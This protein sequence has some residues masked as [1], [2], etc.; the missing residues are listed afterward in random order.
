[1]SFRI[2]GTRVVW[3]AEGEKSE[4][5]DIL[6]IPANDHLW[7]LSGPGLELKKAHGKDFELEA[8][9]LGPLEPGQV[10]VTPGAPCGFRWL[11]HAV[12]MTPELDWSAG[13]GR[14]AALHSIRLAKRAAAS[15]VVFYPLHRGVHGR[16]E[17]PVREM[18]A[19]LLE[20]LGESTGIKSVAVLYHGAEEKALLHETF[21]QLLSSPPS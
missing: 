20:G 15:G 21:L 9:R 10:A 7:M 17:G 8:V 1:M 6:V 14:T 2:L 5:R 12:V 11:H 3:L 16:R 13:A 4:I 19:G 18:L